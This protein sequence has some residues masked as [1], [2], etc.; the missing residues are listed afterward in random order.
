MFGSMSFRIKNTDIFSINTW[1]IVTPLFHRM[2]RYDNE[3]GRTVAAY[4]VGWVVGGEDKDDTLVIE[5]LSRNDTF[6]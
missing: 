3:R 1:Y 2:C 6:R 5:L 4:W